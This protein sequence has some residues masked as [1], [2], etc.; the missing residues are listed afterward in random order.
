MIRIRTRRAPAPTN[1]PGYLRVDSVHQGNQDGLKG[2]YHI[3]TVDSLEQIRKC[4]V[5]VKADLRAI[6]EM[7][8]CPH[9]SVH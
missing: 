6:A 1:R 7:R 2:V 5:K 4:I 8:Q 9:P 3:N